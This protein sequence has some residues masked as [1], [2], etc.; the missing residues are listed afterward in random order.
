M[1]SGPM[2]L[3]STISIHGFAE[4]RV[5]ATDAEACAWDPKVRKSGGLAHLAIVDALA[6]DI[7][8]GRLSEARAFATEATPSESAR[9]RFHHSKPRAPRLVA[10]G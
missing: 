10:Q 5:M 6:T 8:S 7:Q 9:R 4:W 2:L 1:S 3:D